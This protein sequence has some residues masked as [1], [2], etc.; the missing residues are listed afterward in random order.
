MCVPVDAFAPL[1]LLLDWIDTL[2]PELDKQYRIRSTLVPRWKNFVVGYV[3]NNNRFPGTVTSG[4]T[5]VCNLLELTYQWLNPHL[6]NWDASDK[7]AYAAPVTGE[8]LFVLLAAIFLHDIGLTG[9]PRARG[10]SVIE[11][12]RHGVVSADRIRSLFANRDKSS[13][14]LA[15]DLLP[16]LTTKEDVDVIATV[17]AYHQRRTPLTEKVRDKGIAAKRPVL[18][19]S[20]EKLVKE[21]EHL[22][23]FALREIDIFRVISLLRLLDLCDCQCSRAGNVRWTAR[24]L[25][26]NRRLQ[27]TTKREGKRC[28]DNRQSVL[29]NYWKW[30]KQ[31]QVRTI[32]RN[33]VIERVMIIGSEVVYKPL[34]PAHLKQLN[35]C[36]G[37]VAESP[38]PLYLSFEK[39]VSGEMEVVKQFLKGTGLPFTNVRPFNLFKD[40]P[41]LGSLFP[42][43]DRRPQYGK[44]TLVEHNV[45]TLD[46]KVVQVDFRPKDEMTSGLIARPS[47]FVRLNAQWEEN[48]TGE[49]APGLNAARGVFLQKLSNIWST[50]EKPPI[51]QVV[52]PKGAGKTISARTLVTTLEH[53]GDSV[54]HLSL[55]NF[56]GMSPRQQIDNLAELFSSWLAA[57][58]RFVYHLR[59]RAGD[60]LGEEDWGSLFERL[61]SVAQ[62]FI[63]DD[64]DVLHLHEA[65]EPIFRFFVQLLKAVQKRK[66]RVVLCCQQKLISLCQQ[67]GLVTEVATIPPF[68]ADELEVIAESEDM[69][70]EMCGF[71]VDRVSFTPPQVAGLISC[72]P[73]LPIVLHEI[74]NE[75]ELVAPEKDEVA[76]S[77]PVDWS[78]FQESVHR[79]MRLHVT[80]LHASL[81]AA[82]R[83]VLEQLLY[84]PDRAAVGPAQLAAQMKAAP[85]AIKRGWCELAERGLLQPVSYWDLLDDEDEEQH[86]DTIGFARYGVA[87]WW[88]LI[89]S[90]QWLRTLLHLHQ[91]VVEPEILLDEFPRLG[92]LRQVEE[93]N[94]GG[95]NRWQRV[96]NCFMALRDLLS[97]S[98]PEELA[99]LPM[100][101]R[102]DLTLLA[103]LLR[104][105]DPD[106]AFKMAAG[107]GLPRPDCRYVEGIVGFIVKAHPL[108]NDP[109]LS[110]QN[111]EQLLMQ[112]FPYTNEVLHITLVDLL[113]VSRVN[114]KYEEQ[115]RRFLSPIGSF[116][117]IETGRDLRLETG[118]FVKLDDLHRLE[119]S[120]G[121]VYRELLGE[122]ERKQEAGDFLDRSDALSWL[123]ACLGKNEEDTEED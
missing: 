52:G 90:N 76:I 62:Y 85:E 82:G 83:R 78:Y 14:A 118:R 110:E 104:Y 27:H 51:V 33:A 121:P 15:A 4:S 38:L 47:F 28:K 123:A 24:L 19:P 7:P 93:K 58:G 113:E 3:D 61:T 101:K 105:F 49:E 63:F 107:L 106:A 87:P 68:T 17:C 6:K 94:L 30:L 122:A 98:E 59:H 119:V 42:W 71:D 45:T 120:P 32:P 40:L 8:E 22:N 9:P 65:G 21:R 36:L 72:Y 16:T 116:L 114:P 29:H 56:K 109:S 41:A 44:P 12:Q 89:R 50:G 112:L 80:S 115:H 2:S 1:G 67:K 23:K 70:G 20:L 103:A 53:R 64:V 81:T 43:M 96:R 86:E 75:A 100:P 35:E 77:A 34:A 26:D 25:E 74:K 31:R 79:R 60:G 111:I 84:H 97:D 99:S 37:D 46:G 69:W 92:N 73:G 18:G 48:P 88:L 54:L 102:P 39:M 55:S 95:F 11:Y 91:G 117:R 5:H 13:F 108:Y 57:R 66:G 10:V